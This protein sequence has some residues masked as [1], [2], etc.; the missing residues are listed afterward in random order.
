MVFSFK[1]FIYAEML[2]SI[3]GQRSTRACWS[4]FVRCKGEEIFNEA[5]FRWYLHL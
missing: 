4:E 1:S 5:R 3:G 2:E